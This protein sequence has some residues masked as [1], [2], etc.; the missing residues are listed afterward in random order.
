M[1]GEEREAKAVPQAVPRYVRSGGLGGSRSFRSPTRGLRCPAERR[2]L[3]PSRGQE[4]RCRA[5]INPESPETD[6]L[7]GPALL[8]IS[9]GRRRCAG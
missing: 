1:S 4:R 6:S 5:W 8:R 7:R 3:H 2:G 9:L